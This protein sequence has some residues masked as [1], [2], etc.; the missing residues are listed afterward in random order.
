MLPAW[1]CTAISNSISAYASPASALRVALSSS[2]PLSHAVTTSERSGVL[3]AGQLAKAQRDRRII[4]AAVGD[5]A[6]FAVRKSTTATVSI[7]LLPSVSFV[8]AEL[9]SAQ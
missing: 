1:K 6:R 9:I 2:S 4:R 5:A 8:S 3:R 7:S